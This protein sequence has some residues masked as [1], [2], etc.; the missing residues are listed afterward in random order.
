MEKYKFTNTEF[1]TALEKEKILKNWIA[2][3]DSEMKESR[4]TKRLYEH[5]Y[6]NC[7]FIAHY[8]IKGFYNTYFNGDYQD[9]KKFFENINSWGDYQDITGAMIAEYKKRENKIFK[10][11]DAKTDDRFELLKECVKR[12]EMD[13][14][15]RKE[16]LHKIFH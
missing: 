13:L 12:A 15:F 6:L 11:A 1:L 10:E 2:F 14:T 4:F 3:L 5:L 16:V 9:L 7:D 8:N